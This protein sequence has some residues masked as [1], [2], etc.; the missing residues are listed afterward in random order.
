MD[1]PCSDPGLMTPKQEREFDKKAESW[2]KGHRGVPNGRNFTCWNHVRSPGELQRYRAE[3][4]RIF[5][6][7]SI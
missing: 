2:F 1:C 3:Y 4:D 6:K 7:S 5:K